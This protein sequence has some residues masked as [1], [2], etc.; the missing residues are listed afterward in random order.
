MMQT[1]PQRPLYSSKPDPS[2]IE[3]VG[4][5]LR[6]RLPYTEKAYLYTK[7][8]LER[9]MN[10]ALTSSEKEVIKTRTARYR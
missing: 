5:Y 8:E 4:Q 6:C 9:A 1:E 2:T 10:N 3:T 7:A